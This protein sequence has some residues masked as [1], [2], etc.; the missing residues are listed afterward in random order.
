MIN[1]LTA[2]AADTTDRPVFMTVFSSD[3]GPEKWQK[4][5]NGETFLKLFDK[6]HNFFKHGQPLLQAFSIAQAGGLQFAKRVVADDSKLVTNFVA[7]ALQNKY[8]ILPAYDGKE[9]I[10]VDNK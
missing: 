10:K 6:R 5:L 4:N 8:K 1:V 3:K 9:V 7:K 2:P